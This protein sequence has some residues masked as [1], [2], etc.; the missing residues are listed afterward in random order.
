MGMPNPPIP[1]PKSSSPQVGRLFLA[2]TFLLVVIISTHIPSDTDMWW[3][4]RDGQEI[5]QR[6]QILTHDIFS[7]TRPQAPW[8]NAFWLSD[9]GIYAFYQVGRF[10]ALAVAA[11]LL[12][13][14]TFSIVY[15]HTKSPAFLRA[16]V[17]LI[18][19]LAASPFWSARPQ[20]LSYVL[21]ALLDLWLS[22]CWAKRGPA[23]WALPF[24]FALWGNLHGG[25]I[26]GFLL[27]LAYL[28]GSA[29]DLLLGSDQNISSNQLKTLV[30][31]TAVSALA[32]MLN[33]NG[34]AIWVL[35][36]HTVKVSI[37][38]IQEWSSPNFHSLF[39]HPSL[40]L[41]FLFLLGTGLS[42]KRLGFANLLKVIG[43]T[44]MA[45][46]SQRGLAPYAIILA[47]IT[48]EQLTAAW[49]NW[50]RGSLGQ[51][52]QNR[53]QQ[54]SLP[55]PNLVIRALLNVAI[56][57]TISLVAVVRLYTISRPVEVDKGLPVQAVQWIQTN[58]PPGRLFSSYNWGGYLIWNLPDYPVYIDGRADLYGREIINQWW[59]IANGTDQGFTA[60]D[61]WQVRLILVEPS[62]PVVEE[63]PERGWKRLY[64]DNTA[65]IFGR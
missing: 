11:A 62:W 55:Q 35:P 41:L 6:G 13:G 40:W 23:L 58:R 48:I 8:I 29:L 15:L 14:L 36:F 44:Y 17:V 57:G 39:L 4:L 50:S 59:Q 51:R 65:V 27:L 22:R 52:M 1:T 42:Q 43:F 18:A 7:Y 28:V 61:R 26:W 60:L 49:E 9:L 64:Q 32:V 21:L 25:F 34:P 38:G 46:V 47:P 56:L 33:P 12:G 20:L 19:A 45:F 37:A 31:W 16:L 63:L 53:W 2:V 5:W 24:L 3:H 30:V 10:F 54:L